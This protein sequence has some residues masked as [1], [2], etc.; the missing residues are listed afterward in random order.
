MNT[1]AKCDEFELLYKSSSEELG[2][3]RSPTTMEPIVNIKH[4]L[5][6][7]KKPMVGDELLIFIDDGATYED[8]CRI[9]LDFRLPRDEGNHRYSLTTKT[10]PDGI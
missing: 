1:V 4:N 5:P 10:K 9:E 8:I 6:A 3:G 7:K 2:D